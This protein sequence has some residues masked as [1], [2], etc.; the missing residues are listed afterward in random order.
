MAESGRCGASPKSLLKD[1]SKGGRVSRN[2]LAYS[3]Y[4]SK[5]DSETRN[6]KS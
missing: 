5:R 3:K 4:L 1:L 2:D 6:V